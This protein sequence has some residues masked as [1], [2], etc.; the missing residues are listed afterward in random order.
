MKNG[1]LKRKIKWCCKQKD[2]IQRVNN[3]EKSRHMPKTTNAP[4][5]SV[6]QP[7]KR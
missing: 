4:E 2:G 1:E 6:N 5:S 3:N 7:L